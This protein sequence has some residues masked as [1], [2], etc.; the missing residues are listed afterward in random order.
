MRN[1]T[2]KEKDI[3]GELEIPD[4]VYWSINTQR[5]IDNFQVSGKTFPNSFIHSLALVK[6]ACLLANMELK[7]IEKELGEKILETLDEMILEDKFLDQFPLDVFQSGSG[8]QTNMNMNEV[9]ANVTNEKLGHKKGEKEPVHP[10]DHV[11]RSQSSNDVIPTTMHLSAIHVLQKNLLPAIKNTVLVLSF[12][13]DE[14]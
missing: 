6:K 5:A 8:T 10:N 9:V 7:L 13:I 1:N 12:K 4:D 11:N 14:F 3:L 2:R